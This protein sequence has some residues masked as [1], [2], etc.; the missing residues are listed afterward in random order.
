[1]KKQPKN[2]PNGG[3]AARTQPL[4]RPR[5]A[6]GKAPQARKASGAEPVTNRLRKIYD[7]ETPRP[8][9]SRYYQAYVTLLEDG[10]PVTETAIAKVLGISRMSL[11]RIHR[12]NPGLRRWVHVQFRD[13]NEYLV[14][15]VVH[16]LGTTA[17][18]TKSPKHAELFLKAVGAIGPKDDDSGGPSAGISP[19]T[20]IMNYLV[21]APPIPQIVQEQAQQR[22]PPPMTF[23]VS[24]VPAKV[25]VVSTR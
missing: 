22:L 17:I 23:D 4:P 14:G 2:A 1:M 8:S 11:W 3:N 15:P 10:N 12:R 6:R 18:R 13:R 5:R 19:G 21:P 25:P 24:A 7:G 9:W 16:M 20:V